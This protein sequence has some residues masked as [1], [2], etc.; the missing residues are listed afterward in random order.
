[1]RIKKIYFNRM[2]DQWRGEPLYIEDG[3]DDDKLYIRIMDVENYKNGA[4]NTIVADYKDLNGATYSIL[5]NMDFDKKLAIFK[6]PLSILS[7]NGVYEVGFS[8]SFNARNEDGMMLKTAIQTFE[9]IDAIEADDEAIAQ[10]PHYPILVDLINQLANYKV[11][12]SEFPTREEMNQAIE[13]NINSMSMDE[14]LKQINEKGY[15][16]L[17]QL[18][19][20][21]RNYLTKADGSGFAKQSDLNKYVTNIKYLQDLERYALKSSLNN[22][23]LKEQGKTLTTHDLTDELYDKLV[24]LNVGDSGLEVDLSDYQKKVDNTLSTK[25]KSITGAI[26]ELNEGFLKQEDNIDKILEAVDTPPTFT[27]P[28]LNLFIDKTKI[29]HNVATNITL[30][31]SYNKNDAGA[32]TNYTLKKY[33][34][35]L[36]DSSILQT[37]TDNITVSHNNSVVYTATVNYASGES[38]TSTFGVV[39]DGLPSG[40]L[41]VNSSI[42]AYAPSYYGVINNDTITET[43][44]P[45]LI[46]VLNTSK[47]MTTTYKMIN[48]RSVYMYPKNFGALINIRDINNFD[49]INSYTRSEITYNDVDYYVYIL[50]DPVEIDEFKQTFN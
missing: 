2:Y 12:T 8:L 39:Y 46:S 26:N 49:Y 28:T 3:L 33:D 47:S 38:K 13:D 21:L 42:K 1:M 6:I 36:V 43:D 30:T 27:K 22:F 37:Y 20:I 23:V 15:I 34:N 14:I 31:P 24:N 16:T 18:N 32:I 25:D 35:V 9:I 45:N 19:R 17:E 5:G 50:T 7:N 10:D 48:Q 41:S 11:D 40:I 4:I 29:E 44:I